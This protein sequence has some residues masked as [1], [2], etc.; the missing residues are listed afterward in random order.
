LCDDELYWS[1]WIG[2]SV[3]L[4]TILYNTAFHG[5]LIC[6]GRSYTHYLH[7][8]IRLSKRREKEHYNVARLTA[9]VYIQA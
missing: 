8:L 6:M 4:A 9:S 1:V 3:F 2:K 5:H 7:D